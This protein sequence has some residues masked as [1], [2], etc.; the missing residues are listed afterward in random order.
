MPNNM[1]L[2]IAT[3]YDY[4]TCSY[5]GND[6]HSGKFSPQIFFNSSLLR[7]PRSLISTA[8][9]EKLIMLRQE[10]IHPQINALF[11]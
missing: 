1:K 11:C 10:K 2:S 9:R 5:T 6:I 8:C 4:L 3:I 7:D